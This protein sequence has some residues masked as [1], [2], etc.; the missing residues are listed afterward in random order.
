M[1]AREREAD[2]RFGQTRFED[3]GRYVEFH[4]HRF[5]HV[6]R[7]ALARRGTIAVLDDLHTGRSGDDRGGGGDVER[8]ARVPARAAR[9]EHDLSVRVAAG[10]DR[11]NVVAHYGR[12]ADQLFDRRALARQTHEEAADLRFGRATG[13]DL[14]E[15]LSRL[16]ARE[17]LSV[18]ELQQQITHHCKHYSSTLAPAVGVV[19]YTAGSTLNLDL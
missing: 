11:R 18:A 6:G 3:R 8:P 16:L 7:A 17:V 9:V 19:T 5:E 10:V 15:C 13:H 12:G 4:T 14:R 2:V 1:L